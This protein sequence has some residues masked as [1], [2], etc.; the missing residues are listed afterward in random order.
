M[1]NARDVIDLFTLPDPI[2]TRE[3]AERLERLNHERQR[4]EEEILRAILA[5]LEQRTEINDQY[6]L[7]LAG[8][9]WHRGVIG[10]VAQRVVE[11]YHRPAL[12]IGIEDGV[13]VGSGRSIK[14]FHLLDGLTSVSDLFQRFGGHAQAAGFAIAK[15]HIPE[16]TRRFELHARS[17][18]TAADLEPVLR[19][20]AA[21]D[22]AD[23]DWPLYEQLIQLEPFGMGNPT[24]VFGACGARL[25]T[26][27]RIL[28]EKHVKLRVEAGPRAMDALGWGWAARTP[29][30]EP[31]QQV[32]LAF[33][34]EK[35]NYQDMASLQLII[36]DLI[37]T[38]G[39]GVLP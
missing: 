8:E 19:V 3:I 10:I 17:V 21:V 23:V 11:R 20:D 35:N 34:L 27:P 18:L 25:L 7:V 13:G 33:T 16:L 26:A 36:K 1:E 31:G 39:M 32:D 28:Q 4:V 37:A 6:T 14:R 2:R 29:R 22:L 24:P 38:G 12:V 9:G 30:L 15:E 5:E